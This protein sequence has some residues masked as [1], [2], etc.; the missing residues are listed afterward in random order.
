MMQA[1]LKNL[2]SS[3]DRV[4]R[5]L[6]DGTV[7]KAKTAAFK[8]KLVVP[9]N[10]YFDDF[11]TSDTVSNHAPSTSV[12]G[13]YYNIPCLPSYLLSQLCNV[14]TA[15]FVKTCDQK[16]FDNENVFCK[17]IDT[18]VDL[19]TEGLVVIYQEREVRVFFIV[20]FIL[21]DN[22]AMNEIQVL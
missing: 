20:G 10:V 15:G 16:G 9:I 1:V 14:L 7:W 22:L 19:K 3:T 4:I 17:L 12:C 5:S 2:Q 13:I 18:L 8:D 6:V 11:N 21:G